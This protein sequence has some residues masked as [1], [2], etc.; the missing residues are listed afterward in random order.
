MNKDDKEWVD[1]NDKLMNEGADLGKRASLEAI[2]YVQDA[3]DNLNDKQWRKMAVNNQALEMGIGKALGGVIVPQIYNDM[4]KQ[5]HKKLKV[6]KPMA[7]AMADI[8]LGRVIK[9]IIKEV[10]NGK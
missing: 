10:Q 9:N 8:Y 5:F 3:I 4:P 1:R 6:S 2:E 7:Q